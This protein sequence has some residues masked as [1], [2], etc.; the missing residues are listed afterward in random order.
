MAF[1]SRTL[2]LGLALCLPP[3]SQQNLAAKLT[4]LKQVKLDLTKTSRG[5]KALS[6]I[7]FEL[8]LNWFSTG[9]ELIFNW[10]CFFLTRWGGL[11]GLG[12]WSGWGGWGGWGEWG[13]LEWLGW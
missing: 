11:G 3:E 9:F 7:G 8:V 12:G 5:K 13:C 4:S 6:K 1:Q 10:F 2:A